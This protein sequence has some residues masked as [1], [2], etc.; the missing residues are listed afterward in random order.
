MSLRPPTKLHTNWDG[1]KQVLAVDVDGTE[2]TLR[3]IVTGTTETQHV[4]N[5][6]PFLY[7]TDTHDPLKIAIRDTQ[8]HFIVEK[9]LDA[10]VVRSKSSTISRT[11]T[12]FLTKWAGYT[13]PDWQPYKNLRSN[14][15]LHEFL[16]S[17]SDKELR[18]LIPDSF[19]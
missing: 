15:K 3:N 8:E 16:R 4:T 1:P 5:M 11:H 14:L 18:E 6:K 2:Y 12:T 19:Q 10:R 7:E 17:H 9:I 13:T